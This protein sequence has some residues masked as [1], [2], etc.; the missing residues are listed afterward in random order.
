MLQCRSYSVPH[1]LYCHFIFSRDFISP[2]LAITESRE[3]NGPRKTVGTKISDAKFSTL[4][5]TP[6]PELV[7]GK[8]HTV[9]SLSRT[10]LKEMKMPFSH[11]STIV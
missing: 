8:S 3:I 6:N 5:W 9:V 4:D 11:K 1:I 7:K 10:H 2:I